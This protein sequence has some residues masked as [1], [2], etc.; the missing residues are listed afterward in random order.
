MF[1]MCKRKCI[2]GDV[3]PSLLSTININSEYSRGV[4]WWSKIRVC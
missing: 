3:L 4:D 2:L 1:A